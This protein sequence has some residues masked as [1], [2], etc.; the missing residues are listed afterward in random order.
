MGEENNLF[1]WKHVRLWR[2]SSI[3]GIFAALAIIISIFLALGEIYRYDRFAHN[4]FQ[5]NL[6][7]LFSQKPIYIF[8]MSLQM[9]KVLLQGAVFYVMLKGTELGLNMIVETDINYREK[10]TEEASE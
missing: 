4:Q 8:D 10:A 2:F 3:A 7:G 1:D 6:I 5:I 9:V